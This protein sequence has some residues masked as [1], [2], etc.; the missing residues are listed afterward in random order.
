MM[1]FLRLT[2]KH[3][4]MIRFFFFT[5]V[6]SQVTEANFFYWRVRHTSVHAK[7]EKMV[8][9]VWLT[10]Q[11]YIFFSTDVKLTRHW[12]EFL[13]LTCPPHVSGIETHRL[14]RNQLLKR[15]SQKRF[16]QK[17]ELSWVEH[18]YKEPAHRHTFCKYMYSVSAT[19]LATRGVCGFES[20]SVLCL[21]ST[22]YISP[23]LLRGE[24]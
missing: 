24:R 12:S 23:R 5:D 16:R 20:S 18:S 9:D 22:L 19:V 11:W 15:Y 7:C 14:R 10:R 4:S 21:Y 13:L 8:L 2:C 3:K 1:A 6:W 17:H